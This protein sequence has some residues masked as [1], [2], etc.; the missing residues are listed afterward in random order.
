MAGSFRKLVYVFGKKCAG[1]YF[2]R[3]AQVDRFL[4]GNI[5]DPG[6]FIIRDLCIAA[7]AGSIKQSVFDTAL[8]LLVYAKHY[9]LAVH[10]N[11]IRN[12]INR[13]TICLEQKDPGSHDCLCLDCTCLG[14]CLKVRS[15][16]IA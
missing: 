3:V 16:F 11:F 14:L 7:T 6:F 9:A 2:G 1:P 15:V 10:I 13:Q 4:A 12:S 8:K 5:D